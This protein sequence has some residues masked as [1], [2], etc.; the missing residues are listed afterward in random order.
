VYRP[1]IPLLTALVEVSYSDPG[2][3]EQFE[4][5]FSDVHATIAGHLR[6]G[7]D[8]GVVR[9]DIHADETAGWITWMAERGMSQLVAHADPARL[10]RLAESLATIV[11]LTVYSRPVS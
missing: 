8:A 6:A 7:Q 3:R 5:G 2:I 9:E 10:D 11:W 1:H 4:L